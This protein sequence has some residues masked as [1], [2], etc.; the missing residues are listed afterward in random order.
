LIKDNIS[1]RINGTDTENRQKK[2]LR[3]LADYHNVVLN[4]S[5]ETLTKNEASRQIDQLIAQYG[6]M[7]KPELTQAHT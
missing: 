5:W 1:D 2:H 6:R 3:Q 4:I 7:P